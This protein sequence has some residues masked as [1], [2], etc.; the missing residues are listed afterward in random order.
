MQ[1][2]PDYGAMSDGIL[3]AGSV[4]QSAWIRAVSGA[5]LPGMTRTINSPEYRDG[6][7]QPRSLRTCSEKRAAC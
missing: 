3:R 1:Q 7:T 2:E 6:L 4:I 5:K